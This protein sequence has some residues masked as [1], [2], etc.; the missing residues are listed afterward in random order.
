MMMFRCFSKYWALALCL[1][2]FVAGRA[3]AQDAKLREGDQIE[4]RIGG[5][6]A[7]EITQI[8]GSYTIDG[9]GYVNMPHIGR[10]RAAGCT[11]GQLQQAIQSGYRDQQ[12]YTNPSITVLIPT[13]ARFVNV[14]GSVRNSMRVTPGDQWAST[15]PAS[16]ASPH[17]RASTTRHG[18]R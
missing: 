12:I 15:N 16:M 8:N 3:F 6:P 10:V 17:P 13:T 5:I 9:E 2:A 14:E 18:P 1:T 11:Q 4:I 7:A